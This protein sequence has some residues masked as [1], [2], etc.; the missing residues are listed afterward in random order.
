MINITCCLT[1]AYSRTVVVFLEVTCGDES[2]TI[3]VVIAILWMK[4]FVV[5]QSLVELAKCQWTDMLKDVWVLSAGVVLATLKMLQ[6]C[7]SC[8]KKLTIH[9]FPPG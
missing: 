3:D 6:V 8:G 9:Q 4:G 2:R 1:A 7:K 5:L